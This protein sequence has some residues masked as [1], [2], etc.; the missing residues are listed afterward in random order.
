MTRRTCA[1]PHTRL[2]AEGEPARVA[3]G[4]RTV[5]RRRPVAD[6]ITE[7]HLEG[8]A[9]QRGPS[10]RA[11]LRGEG[12]LRRR[13]GLRPEGRSLSLAEPTRR[14]ASKSVSGA[15]RGPFAE[16]APS[17]RG[18]AAKQS[19]FREP[20]AS[21]LPGQPA[22]RA[23]GERPAARG[24]SS[25]EHR[26]R[27]GAPRARRDDREYPAIFEGGATQPAGMHRRPNAV[28]TFTT[29]C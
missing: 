19:A 1:K 4:A 6:V 3:R 9:A 25:G 2:R 13:A 24:E 14:A 16:S 29:G 10:P 23:E 7:R 5:R 11:P 15:Q 26:G 28:A 18:P 12:R 8:G 27:R 17:G 20:T 21:D 22:P